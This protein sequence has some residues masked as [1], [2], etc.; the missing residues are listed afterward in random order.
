M[1]QIPLQGGD[2]SLDQ[3]LDVHLTAL[4][5]PRILPEEPDKRIRSPSAVM[6]GRPQEVVQAVEG[7]APEPFLP[8][9]VFE[10]LPDRPEQ[11]G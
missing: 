7:E 8:A 5:L 9:R 2:L 4:H 3:D 6:D 10:E 11:F 1:N